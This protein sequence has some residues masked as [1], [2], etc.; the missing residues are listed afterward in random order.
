MLKVTDILAAYPLRLISMAWAKPSPPIQEIFNRHRVT[1]C[2]RVVT[3]AKKGFQAR[4]TRSQRELVS[5]S[6]AS[7]NTTRVFTQHV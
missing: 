2:Q 1:A 6:S 7:A 5:I 4:Q 3:A